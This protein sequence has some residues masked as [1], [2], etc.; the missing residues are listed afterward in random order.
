MGKFKKNQNNKKRQNTNGYFARNS[1]QYGKDFIKAKRDDEIRRD[2]PRIF[3]DIAFCMGDI[4][5]ISEFFLE[6]RFVNVLYQYSATMYLEY[7]TTAKG[8]MAYIKDNTNMPLDPK[9]QVDNMIQTKTKL[10]AAYGIIAQSLN[11]ILNVLTM[12]KHADRLALYVMIS[13]V[14]KQM[15]IQLK[16][17]RYIL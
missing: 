14:L 12:N 6:K 13:T 16:D 10:A 11:N 9:A 15:S 3:K 1:K 2:A 7:D 8:L 4:G 5:G 17:Y